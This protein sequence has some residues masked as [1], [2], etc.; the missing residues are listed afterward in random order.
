MH[1]YIYMYMHI[2][3]YNYIHIYLRSCT[4]V[5]LRDKGV[6]E[7]LHSPLSLY[8][9]WILN[10]V[11]LN[12]SEVLTNPCIYVNVS[13]YIYI[14]IYIHIYM[15]IYIYIHIHICTYIYLPPGIKSNG[16][17]STWTSTASLALGY[18]VFVLDDDD[19]H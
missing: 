7:G 14:Y 19:I 12:R 1:I 9:P 2:Y 10:E 15:F 11:K 16:V 18:G 6:I 17:S 3:I 13:V 8:V 5:D 4:R